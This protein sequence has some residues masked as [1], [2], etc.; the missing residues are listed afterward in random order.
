MNLSDRKLKERKVRQDLILDGA[1][2]VFKLK[3]I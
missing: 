1:L 2:Q 3:G